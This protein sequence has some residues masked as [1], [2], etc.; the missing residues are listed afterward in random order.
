MGYS[1]VWCEAQTLIKINLLHKT[2]SATWIADFYSRQLW[3]AWWQVQQLTLK[4]LSMDR[5]DSLQ[6]P[7]G[8]IETWWKIQTMRWRSSCS[9]MLLPLFI[10]CLFSP[11]PALLF[12]RS[13]PGHT[14]TK[15]QQMPETLLLY[16]RLSINHGLSGCSSSTF[17]KSCH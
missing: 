14:H 6:L 4:L 5:G 12:Q 15:V 9:P 16:Y 8:H 3:E 13:P 10:L 2:D 11:S 7:L 1:L 17:L